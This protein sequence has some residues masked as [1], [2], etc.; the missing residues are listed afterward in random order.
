MN[1]S[2]AIFNAYFL[3]GRKCIALLSILFII[4]FSPEI[5]PAETSR[6]FRI[7]DAAGREVSFNKLPR[8]IVVIGIGPFMAMDL[9]YMFP[10]VRDRLAGYEVKFKIKNDFLPLVDPEFQHKATLGTNPGPEQV[11]ALNPDLVIMKGT[12]PMPIG[13]SLRV[14]GIPAVYLGLETPD[15][16]FKDVENLGLLFGN[17]ERAR[18]ISDYYHQVLD[19]INKRIEFVPEGERPRV[20]VL[21]YSDRG[22]KVAVQVPA[23]SWM[24]TIQ[25][26]V[27][28][29]R[30][31]WLKSA[32]PTD[33]WTITN[34]EQIAA[35]DPDK[36]FAMIW[37]TLAP[38]KV[39]ESLKADSSWRMLKAVRNNDLYAFPSDIFGWS[40]P[41]PRWI[42]GVQWL[43][44]KMHPDLFPDI[45]I[46][47]EVFRYFTGMYF[48]E[49]GVVA[50]KII[51]SIYLGSE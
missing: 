2:R 22:G 26:L 24:Q 15:L 38:G 51:P 8:R 25:A 45:D 31:V 27:A 20:L 12:V 16:F 6:P 30:P 33:G 17:P 18:E 11:A 44:K 32:H 19:R 46:K 41:E 28:G 7:K 48:L 40:T 1:L 5:T 35:W 9:I 29:G 39:I 47:A 36:I 34:F 3:T 43:A 14:M 42:L 10:E 21:E 4:L 13:E 37:F 49:E 23:R 50:S